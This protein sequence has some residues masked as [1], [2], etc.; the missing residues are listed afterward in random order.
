M[1]GQ[2]SGAGRRY[3]LQRT[4]SSKTADELDNKYFSYSWTDGWRADIHVR[5]MLK[6][7]R[8]GK[9]DGFCG[10]DWMVYNILNHGDPR[11]MNKDGTFKDP[12]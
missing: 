3:A 2:W 12:A 11:D 5:K 4:V 8:L 7:E 10:Y 9:T 1:P 6:G